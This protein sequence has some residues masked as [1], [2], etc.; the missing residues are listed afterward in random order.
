MTTDPPLASSPR[1]SQGEEPGGDVV[2]RTEAWDA[3]LPMRSP[4]FWPLGAAHALLVEAMRAG[5]GA[6]AGTETGFPQ[7]ETIDGALG[8]RAG[9]RFERQRPVS[10]R[11][12]GPRDPASMYDARI[13]KEGCVPTRPGSWHD[14]M[15][16]LVWATFPRAKRA[17]H[18][19]QHGLVV[20]AAPG[21][22][23]R[24]PRELD[25]LAL[26][27]EGGL[28]VIADGSLVAR[29]TGAGEIAEREAAL[30]DAI[31][32]GAATA[33]VFG[34][35]IYEGLVLGRPAPLASVVVCAASSSEEGRI[36]DEADRALAAVL[37]DRSR[38][39]DPAGMLRLR[40]DERLVSGVRRPESRPE[41]G[42]G[43]SP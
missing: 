39:V 10:R 43:G 35:A 26:L 9:V 22:S 17:L 5:A 11:R 4:L 20:P 37:A 7:P 2:C 42:A 13:A 33:L 14:L 24:R 27:D 29:S 28:V 32:T 6:G 31:A 40:A 21:E 34:H 8:G 16:A 1:A 25:A 18:E 3:G 12:R 36:I 19:R 41:P 23:A 38:I 30:E 15:N